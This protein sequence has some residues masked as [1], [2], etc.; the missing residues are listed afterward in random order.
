VS[1][2]GAP[3]SLNKP[4]KWQPANAVS[5]EGECSDRKTAIAGAAA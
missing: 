2:N 5:Q 3:F 4:G 1:T